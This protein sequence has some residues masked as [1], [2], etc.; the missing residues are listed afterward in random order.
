MRATARVRALRA[1]QSP[2]PGRALQR[3]AGVLRR[4]ST[5]SS[6]PPGGDLAGAAERSAAAKLKAALDSGSAQAEARKAA[7]AAAVGQAQAKALAGEGAH[8]GESGVSSAG[9]GAADLTDES[10]DAEDQA[11][12]DK[13]YNAERGEYGGPTGLEPTRFSDWEKN[14]RCSDF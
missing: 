10:L 8:E 2:V 1:M 6:A 11:V 13:Y 7:A 14:G 12:A 4:V 3:L 5:G 9:E